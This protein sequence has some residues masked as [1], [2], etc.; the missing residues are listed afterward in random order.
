MPHSL[1]VERDRFI[2][3]AFAIAIAVATGDVL[4]ETDDAG[5]IRFATGALAR[6]PPAAMALE[7][8]EGR[9]VLDFL[10]DVDRGLVGLL[11]NDVE[12]GGRRGPVA[13]ANAGGTAFAECSLLRA[14][15]L[16]GCHVVLRRL[17]DGSPRR[18][19]RSRSAARRRR[20]SAA[21]A[22]RWCT[23]ATA[24]VSA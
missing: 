10:D 6:F 24:E 9:S 8:L 20:S 16:S 15:Q 14:P 19:G 4:A 3:F 12:R 21:T 18:S 1:A 2:A 13:V 17:A 22:S 11:L 5:R 23:T 7:A